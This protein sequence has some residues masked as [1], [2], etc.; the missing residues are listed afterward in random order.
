MPRPVQHPEIIVQA[1]RGGAV[2]SLHRACAALAR[3]D[4]E[5]V[6]RWGDPDMVTFWRSAAKPLQAQAWVADGTVARFG[7]GTEELALMS[8]SHSGLDTHADLVRRMLR[9]VGLQEQDLRCDTTR[10]ARHACSGNHTGFLAACVHHDWDVPTYARPDHPAQQTAL[11]AFAALTDT[12]PDTLITGVDGCG[13]VCYATPVAAIATTFA[14]LPELLPRIG[15]AMRA[16]PE[17]VAGPGRL[18]TE[19]MRAAPGATSKFGAEGLSC[20]SLPDGRGLAVKVIDGAARARGP[21]ALAVLEAVLGADT[22]TDG[23]LR[24]ARPPIENELGDVVGEVSA[25]IPE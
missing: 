20:I 13:I 22:M 18:D 16:H 23:L 19:V 5:I 1:R 24:L 10:K 21:A 6:E 9:D 17:L 15:A 8:A 2:E 3:P 11:R 14:L 4:G 12:D 7:W 25:V